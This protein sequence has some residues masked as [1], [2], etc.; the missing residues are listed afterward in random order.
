M[1]GSDPPLKPSARQLHSPRRCIYPCPN[2][3]LSLGI[4]ESIRVA[5]REVDGTVQG[6]A[7]ETPKRHPGH[8]GL[9]S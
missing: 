9:L 3:A 2:S 7:I 1:E 6:L 5:P 4:A 8:P